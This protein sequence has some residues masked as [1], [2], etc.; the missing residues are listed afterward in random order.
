M[1]TAKSA[2]VVTPIETEGGQPLT[3]KEPAAWGIGSCTHGVRLHKGRIPISW[4]ARTALLIRADV[5]NQSAPTG[6]VVK[7]NRAGQHQQAGGDEVL[8]ASATSREPL[9]ITPA[10]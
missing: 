8:T 3:V 1:S 6:Q 7:I 4:S 9:A 5:P 10:P 2:W